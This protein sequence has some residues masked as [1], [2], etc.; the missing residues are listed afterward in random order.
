MRSIIERFKKVSTSS[1]S[2]ALDSLGVVTSLI[3][4]HPQVVGA[5]CV[6]L[7]F[8]VEYMPYNT[9]L[10]EFRNASNYIDHVPVGAVIVID[11][12]GKDNCTV[13]GDILTAFAVHRG[14]AGTI[15]HGAVRDISTIRELNYPLFSSHIFMKSGKNRVTKRL[16]NEKITISGVEIYPNDLMVADENGC[17]CVPQKLINEVLVRAEQVEKTEKAIK[18]AI[19]NGMTLVE[20]RKKFAYRT[21]WKKQS[22]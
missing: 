16:V 20:A 19:L 4:I 15:V 17:V 22:S 5:R 14:I 1:V 12:Q 7:A 8:T 9:T 3:G 6:G 2:D 13:W 11:N 18:K 10:T 21:P